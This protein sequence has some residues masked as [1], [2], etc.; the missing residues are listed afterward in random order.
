MICLD[1]QTQSNPII[2][3]IKQLTDIIALQMWWWILSLVNTT[4]G[5]YSVSDTGGSEGKIQV[6]PMGVE[7]M[8]L[9][10]TSP[11]ALPLSYRTLMGAKA[12][13]LQ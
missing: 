4:K 12:T 9:L 1:Q 10:F 5:V 2:L 3:E 8:T 11:D 7:P 6:L 13:K